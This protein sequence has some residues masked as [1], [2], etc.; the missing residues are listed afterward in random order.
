MSVLLILLEGFTSI[1]NPSVRRRDLGLK[2]LE[3]FIESYRTMSDR[4]RLAGDWQA[5]QRDML[6]AWK[7][8]QSSY[9]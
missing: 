9:K 1:F 2:K 8:V 6:R 3:K 5:V 7:K 4:E